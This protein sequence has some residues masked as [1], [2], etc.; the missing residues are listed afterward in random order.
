MSKIKKIVLKLV[1][2]MM[3]ESVEWTRDEL[4]FLSAYIKSQETKD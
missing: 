4:V 3:G 2:Q 1:Q